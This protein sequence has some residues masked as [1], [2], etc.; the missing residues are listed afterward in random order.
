MTW[1]LVCLQA[2][3]AGT[4]LIGIDLKFRALL[5]GIAFDGLILNVGLRRVF[6]D[7]VDALEAGLLGCIY[8]RGADDHTIICRSRCTCLVLRGSSHHSREVEKKHPSDLQKDAQRC[9]RGV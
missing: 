8:F 1:P 2:E 6:H 5:C 7:A 4:A 9:A 3:T